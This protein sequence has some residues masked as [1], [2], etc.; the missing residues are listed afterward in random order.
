MQFLVLGDALRV[1]EGV[2]LGEP[3][4]RVV[5]ATLCPCAGCLRRWNVALAGI[6]LVCFTASCEKSQTQH[7]L[8][9][10]LSAIWSKPLGSVWTQ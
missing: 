3:C 8:S 5:C 10:Y 1:G 6:L 4:E 7:S 9:K 2:P